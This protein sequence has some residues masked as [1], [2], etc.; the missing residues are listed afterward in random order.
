MTALQTI[1]QCDWLSTRHY[2]IDYC[3]VSL[4]RNADI[5]N[6]ESFTS[7]WTISPL[8]PTDSVPSFR[9]YEQKRWKAGLSSFRT[10]VWLRVIASISALPT[11]M[12]EHMDARFLSWEM[13]DSTTSF[14]TIARLRGHESSPTFQPLAQ[15]RSHNSFPSFWTG[16]TGPSCTLANSVW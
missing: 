10:I 5:R 13:H 2:I 4:Q 15:L 1:V 8:R 16:C 12:T 9:T 7:L 11:F 3:L 6:Q 14:R